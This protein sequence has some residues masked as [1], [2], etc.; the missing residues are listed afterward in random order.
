MECTDKRRCRGRKDLRCFVLKGFE[1]ATGTC[2]K[3]YSCKVFVSI[4]VSKFVPLDHTL[5]THIFNSNFSFF[6]FQMIYFK[7]N[8]TSVIIIFLGKL[9]PLV[10]NQLSDSDSDYFYSLKVDMYLYI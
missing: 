10:A 3:K 6:K 7:P 8:E 5:S 2:Q 4:Y 1:I 9:H